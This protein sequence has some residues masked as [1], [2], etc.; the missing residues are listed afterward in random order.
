MDQTQVNNLQGLLVTYKSLSSVHCF[1]H[2]C[3]SYN[4]KSQSEYI[5][6][7]HL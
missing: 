4:N 2:N 1:P 5:Q 6:K 7:G 3:H